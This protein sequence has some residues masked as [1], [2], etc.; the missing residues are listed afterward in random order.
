MAFWISKISNL[1]SGTRIMSAESFVTLSI[2]L[3][4]WIGYRSIW[5]FARYAISIPISS[6]ALVTLGSSFRLSRP[7]YL[8]GDINKHTNADDIF[9]RRNN[10]IEFS[11][12][13]RSRKLK[14]NEAQLRNVKSK[15][16]GKSDFPW[17]LYYKYNPSLLL[18]TVLI[19]IDNHTVIK[20]IMRNYIILMTV[21]YSLVII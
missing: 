14:S 4:R 18:I 9:V 5:Y 11:K 7:I 6:Y 17:W 3:I 10:K 1:F 21:I 12:G 8:P 20:H 16:Q 13:G 2:R 19:V 15:Y